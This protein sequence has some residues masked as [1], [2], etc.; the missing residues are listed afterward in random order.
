MAQSLSTKATTTV[1]KTVIIKPKTLQKLKDELKAYGKLK[2][3][4]EKIKAKMDAGKE[5][6][7][8]LREST[9]EDKLAVDGFSIALVQPV[10]AVLNHEKLIA[11][12]CAVSWIEEATEHK[13][14]KPYEKITCPGEKD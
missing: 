7:G 8:E 2:V 13:P 3:E 9:G 1:T 5:R 10:R 14:T 4:L 11:L 12:G 6:I